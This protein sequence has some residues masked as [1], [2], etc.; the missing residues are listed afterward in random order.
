ML[1][2]QQMPNFMGYDCGQFLGSDLFTKHK[3][4]VTGICITH[5]HL[6]GQS[7]KLA[8]LG[9]CPAIPTNVNR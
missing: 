4:I 1:I 3:A 8:V 6:L 2:A 5:I 7:K 9:E